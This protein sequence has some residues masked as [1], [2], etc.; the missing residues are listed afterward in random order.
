M[1]INK[2]QVNIVKH[3]RTVIGASGPWYVTI[4]RVNQNVDGFDNPLYLHNDGVWRDATCIDSKSGDVWSGYYKSEAAARKS[5]NA[6]LP[7]YNG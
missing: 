5:F 4:R 1:I 7:T 3:S 2:G 6:L